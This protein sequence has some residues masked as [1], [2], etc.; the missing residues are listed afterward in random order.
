MKIQ[1]YGVIGNG[2]SA[3]LISL[4]GS[5][6]WLAWPRFDSAS[7][8]AATIPAHVDISHRH[9]AVDQH[10]V[11]RELATSDKNDPHA[12]IVLAAILSPVQAARAELCWSGFTL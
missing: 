9:Q 4:E 10:V 7:I 6:D 11:G 2:R 1:D 12:G 8:F 5:L 3:A